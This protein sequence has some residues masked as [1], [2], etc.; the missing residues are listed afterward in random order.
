[1]F[2]SL[3]QCCVSRNAPISESQPRE[4]RKEFLLK[5]ENWMSDYQSKRVLDLWVI[6]GTHHSGVVRPKKRVSQ[7]VWGWAQTQE[8][9]IYEQLK[10]GIRFLDLRVRVSKGQVI[11]SH[12]L[13]SDIRLETA[14]ED[15][16]SFLSTH[17]TEFVL[18]YVRADKW[19]EMTAECVKNV[20]EALIAS[21]VSFFPAIDSLASIKVGDLAGKALYFSPDVTIPKCTWR[22]DLLAYC[23]VWQETSI[24]EAQKRI[25]NYMESIRERT[26]SDGALSGVALDGAFPVKQQCY[27]SK[28][29]NEWFL[30]NL[31]TNKEWSGLR[32]LGLCIIDF[33][34]EEFVDQLLKLNKAAKTVRISEPGERKTINKRSVAG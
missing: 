29:L 26:N 31:K 8:A 33:A 30:K 15:I 10:F 23:D 12:G 7:A 25:S 19:H 9:S 28:E 5:N 1:M 14:L 34:T 27:T 22:T 4:E 13:S 20:R 32:T 16:K 6:P 24:E 11:L 3:L 18:V 17:S 21:K 2:T